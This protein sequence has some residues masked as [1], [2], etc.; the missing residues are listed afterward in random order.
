MMDEFNP[1]PLYE[2]YAHHC[3]HCGKIVYFDI[4]EGSLYCPECGQRIPDE[5]LS[6][7]EIADEESESKE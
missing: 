4:V 7:P 3:P 2:D 5:D 1:T 6:D